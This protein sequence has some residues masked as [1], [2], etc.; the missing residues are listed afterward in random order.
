MT[1]SHC[2]GQAL[3]RGPLSSLTHTECTGCGA[4]NAQAPDQTEDD[5]DDE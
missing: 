2:G 3:W 5:H 1:C 4:I